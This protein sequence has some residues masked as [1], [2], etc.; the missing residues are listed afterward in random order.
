MPS[1]SKRIRSARASGTAVIFD[2]VAALRAHG[3][4]VLSLAVGEPDFPTPPHIVEATKGALDGG[5]T[6]YTQVA[7]LL[8]LRRAICEDSERRRGVA[9]D[10]SQVVV[11]AGAKHALFNLA[12]VLFDPGDRVVIPTPCWASYVE[13]AR[14]F[15]ATA[16]LLPTTAEQGFFPT[17]EQLAEALATPTKAIVLCA[18]SNPTGAVPDRAQWQALADV[19]R[20]SD[21]F[22]IL[23]EIYGRLTLDGCELSLLSVAPELRDR[24][25][26]VDGV[27][28]TFAMTGFRVGWSLTSSEL[29]QAIVTLQSQATT[30]V[31]T[32]AQ[33]AAEAALTGDQAPVA[34]QV[35][36]FAARR[37]LLC[38]GLESID[39]LEVARMP[40]GAFYVLVDARAWLRRAP[41]LLPN[42][43]A[44]A[45]QLLAQQ[46]LAV[47]PGSAF[48]ADGC[49]RLSFAAARTDIREALER[50]RAFG[51]SL[52]ALRD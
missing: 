25:A 17:A 41:A 45:Q 33:V 4:S 27:S 2:E 44:L 30:N 28:K 51:A 22:V 18:P 48:Y 6:R 19:L 35:R 49:L 42:D 26:I 14:L 23:D 21:A 38:V 3:Q 13:Q 12:G 39:G 32:M 11:S 9:H 24:I 37:E 40:S 31:A 43:V 15:G 5:Q 1:L 47:V 8:S 29:A 34:N 10:P 52:P 46:Q 50:L 7:G 16:E 20:E 36:E